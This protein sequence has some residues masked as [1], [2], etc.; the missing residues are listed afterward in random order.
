MTGQLNAITIVMDE[1]KLSREKEQENRQSRLCWDWMIVSGNCHY[2]KDR[3][4][5]KTYRRI[6]KMIRTGK[7]FAG[8]RDT[9]VSG[10]GTVELKVCISSDEGS[11]NGVLVLENV[12]HVSSAMCNGF[13]PRKYHDRNGGEVTDCEGKWRGSRRNGEPLW[14]SLPFVGFQKLALAGNP[15]GDSSFGLNAMF[16]PGWDLEI[17][18]KDLKSILGE[19]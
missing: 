15:Q 18:D 10:I 17:S 11:P 9:F 13:N 19:D 8:L 1:I 12:L 4:S 3:S 2:T 14:E 6:E 16:F 5:F 7:T